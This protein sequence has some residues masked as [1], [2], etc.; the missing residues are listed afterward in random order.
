MEPGDAQGKPATSVTLRPVLLRQY[1]SPTEAIASPD[2][3]NAPPRAQEAPSAEPAENGRLAERLWALLQPPLAQLIA[4]NG[5]LE[6]PAEI[7]PFQCEGIACLLD[8]REVLLADEMGLGKTVQAIAALR[9]LAFRGR[10]RSALVVC[11]AGLMVQWRREIERWAPELVAAVV[12]GRPEDRATLWRI[13]AHLYL[14]SYET[15]RGDV[16]DLRDSPALAREW[17]VVVLDEA[18]RIRNR[19]TGVSLACRRLRRNRRWALTGTPL[20]NRLEDVATILE[21][22]TGDPQRPRS[23]QPDP[24]ILRAHLAGVQLRRKKEDVLPELPPK[25]IHEVWLELNPRQRLAYDEAES[26]GIVR[27]RNSAAPVTVTHVLELISRLKQICNCDPVSCESAKLDDIESRLEDVIASGRRALL[28]SQYTDAQYGVRWLAES[29]ARFNPIEYT[30]AMS[31]SERQRAVDAFEQSQDHR[32]MALSLRAGSLGLNLQS[33]SYV[34]H[35]DRWWNPAIES[36][37]EDRAHR[38]GQTVPVTVYRYIC[39]ATIEERIDAKLREKRALFD[40]VV[41]DVSLDLAAA[42]TNEE[43][44]GLFG[45]EAPASRPRPARPIDHH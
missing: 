17:D 1:D 31:S 43:L 38:M 42:F 13:P 44:F 33:A 12:R 8:R 35:V 4:P 15:L 5:P 6:W 21:F 45:L 37:A 27:L 10:L 40:Q 19:D 11:P 28:F 22:L 20:E 2:R 39:A 14:V 36:Q 9:I 24:A 7:R 16:L 30:G 25:D 23:V 41:D 34:F 29:L 32:I 26:A 18:S 3:A